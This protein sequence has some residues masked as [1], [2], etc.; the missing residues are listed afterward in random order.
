VVGTGLWIE[1]QGIFGVNDLWALVSIPASAGLGEQERKQLQQMVA[2]AFRLWF[3]RRLTTVVS[4]LQSAVCRPAL[5]ALDG[6]SAPD[7]ARFDRVA[8]ALAA[9]EVP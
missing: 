6:I 9:L 2:P 8:R 5:E 4:V 7:D 3:E 1:L